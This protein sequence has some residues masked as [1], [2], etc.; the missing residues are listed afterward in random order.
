MWKLS[1]LGE[2][3]FSGYVKEPCCFLYTCLKRAPG[4][5]S[6]YQKRLGETLAEEYAIQA[7]STVS[8]YFKMLLV[9]RAAE[10]CNDEDAQEAI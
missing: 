2:F 8:D 9:G 10:Q 4:A 6:T 1:S 7:K 3:V 5:Y